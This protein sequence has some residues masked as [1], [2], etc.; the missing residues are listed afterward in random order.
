MSFILLA[1]PAQLIVYL[2]FVVISI[3]NTRQQTPVSK[4]TTTPVYN[5]KDA[6]FDFPIYLSLADKLGVVEII[7]WDKDMLKKEYLGEVALPL[8]DWFVDKASGKERVYGFD[9]PG[10]EVREGS[11][12][13]YS[14]GYSNFT[15]KAISLNLVSTRA[16]T[17]ST[18]SVQIKFGF[19]LTPNSNNLMEFDE[20]YSE[21]VKRTR[22][23]LV[24]APPVKSHL[25][26]LYLALIID[27]HL[28]PSTRSSFISHDL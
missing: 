26:R 11:S 10:N 4:R 23:S 21:L 9:Q 15:P 6:T 28:I 7:V 5:A 19:V 2:S 8:E 16:N 24:S 17:P 1:W 12:W 25:L 14:R 18:G 27:I 22:P 20:I 13:I 3:L